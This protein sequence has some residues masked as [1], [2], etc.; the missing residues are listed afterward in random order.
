[1]SPQRPPQAKTASLLRIERLT[2]GP[3]ALIIEGRDPIVGAWS[4]G[5]HFFYDE[6]VA[7]Y[8]FRALDWPYLTPVLL[9]GLLG[10]IVLLFAVGF[11]GASLAAGAWSFGGL[12]AALVLLGA[13]R[14]LL[15]RRPVVRLETPSGPFE[16][17]TRDRSFFDRFLERLPLSEERTE[18]VQTARDEDVKTTTVTPETPSTDAPGPPPEVARPQPLA[19]DAASGP[20]PSGTPQPDEWRWAWRPE[21]EMRPDEG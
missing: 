12:W 18:V 3:E 19:E 21:G 16:F 4:P 14:I 1:M 13:Y 7:V 10:G 6:I 9:Y 8:R 11:T 20:I 2:L 5:K 17:S 15:V